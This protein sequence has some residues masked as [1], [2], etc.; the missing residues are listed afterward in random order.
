MM[1]TKNRE[2]R[3]RKKKRNTI[4]LPEDL[5]VEILSRVPEASLARFRS[6]SKGWNALIKKVVILTK[7]SL[8]LMLIDFRVYSASVDLNGIQKNVVKLT[9]QFSLK[10]PLCNP[11]KEVDI[12]T[13]YHS[14]GLLLC[15]TKDNR[16]VAW[17]PRSGETSWVEPRIPH[18]KIGIYALGKSSCNKY[19]ILRIN[20][21]SNRDKGLVEYEVY[22]FNSKSWRVTVGDETRDWSIIGLRPCGMSVNGNTYWL[23]D[24]TGGRFIVS[25]EFSTERLGRVSLPPTSHFSYDV[26]GLSVTREEQ[27]LCLLTTQSRV[28]LDIIDLWRATKIESSGAT[29]WSKFL[30][31]DSAFLSHPFRLVSGMN[32][33]ADREKR[34][35]VCPG[36]E[37]NSNSFLLIMGEDK[38]IQVDHR[39]AGFRCS[40]LLNYVPTL[41]QIQ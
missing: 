11:S 10:D 18:E 25:F 41:V 26:R 39:D 19:K 12:R 2:F 9:S 33:L 30:S 6:I 32:F 34:V 7:K 8:I 3:K 31:V 4:D 17:N 36:G 15:T 29:S 24:G 35:L 37:G 16:L 22:D 21:I 28:V 14:D 20:Q 5:V 13:V 38:Y 27:Q 1:K 23:A 40:L